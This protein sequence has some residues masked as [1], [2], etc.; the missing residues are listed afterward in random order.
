[1]QEWVNISY[2]RGFP[3]PRDGTYEP[4]SYFLQWQ[5]DSL[6]LSHQGSACEGL[7]LFA[8]KVMSTEKG[9]WT[10]ELHVVFREGK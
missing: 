7:E 5:V 1:M 10:K 4:A 8:N 3:Q 2:T 9:Y 6:L